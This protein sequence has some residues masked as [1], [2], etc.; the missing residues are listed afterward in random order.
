MDYDTNLDLDATVDDVFGVFV[1]QQQEQISQ[2]FQANYLTRNIAGVAGLYYFKEEDVTESGLFG[3]VI[4]LVTNS[5]N[6]QEN[7]SYAA[8]G[9]LDYFMNEKLSIT[10][11]LRYTKEEKT[12][13]GENIS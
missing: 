8:Y 9:N 2:E 3:P 1:F 13:S 12:F 11:G 7:K 4:S 10:A 5:E 6:D